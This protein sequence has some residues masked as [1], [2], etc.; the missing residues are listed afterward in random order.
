SAFIFPP[1]S[2]VD[3]GWTIYSPLKP[4]RS[5]AFSMTVIA[6]SS[7][8][9]EMTTLSVDEPSPKKEKY[10]IMTVI[11]PST[12]IFHLLFIRLILSFLDNVANR[13]LYFVYIH[14]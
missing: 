9:V 12:M 6:S 3:C 11:R 10:R 5:K 8:F 1:N 14:W 7:A 13:Y 2:A 4:L